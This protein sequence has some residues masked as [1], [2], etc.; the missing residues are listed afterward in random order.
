MN[1]LQN[2]VQR[3]YVPVMLLLIIGGF[4]MLLVELLMLDH[5]EGIQLVAVMATG[6][7]LLLA[8]AAL[9]APAK[10]RNGV[11]ILFVLLSVTGLIGSYEHVEEGAEEEEEAHLVMPTTENNANLNIAYPAQAAKEGEEEGEEGEEEGED[12]PPPLAPLSLA[13][14]ALMGAVTTLAKREE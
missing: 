10:W 11:A 1:M 12:V 7:G 9:L 5:T 14:F 8:L 13:G 3:R 4:V 2:F 6:M